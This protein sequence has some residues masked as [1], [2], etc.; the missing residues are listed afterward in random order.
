[1]SDA[2]AT[3]ISRMLAGRG[4]APSVPSSDPVLVHTGPVPATGDQKALWFIEQ[5]NQ[6]APLYNMAYAVTITGTP[7][8]EAVRR[9]VV[10]LPRRHDALRTGVAFSDGDCVQTRLED[11]SI[12]WTAGPC[13]R[14]SVSGRVRDLVLTP[15]ELDRPPL[16]R[17]ALWS[18]SP[19]EHVF[20]LVVHHAVADG[21]ALSLLVHDVGQNYREEA[22]REA[23]GPGPTPEPAEP[24]PTFA[25]FAL[26]QSA[27]RT[28]G[29]L[30][31]QLAW[32]VAHLGARPSAPAPEAA[33]T[34]S[35]SSPARTTSGPAPATLCELTFSREETDLVTALARRIGTSPFVVATAALLALVADGAGASGA[36]TV[37]TAVDRRG[38]DFADVVGHFVNTVLIRPRR[39]PDEDFTSWARACA[40]AL[41]EAVRNGDVPF[42]EVAAATAP[43][44]GTHRTSLCPIYMV[45]QSVSTVH[46]LAGFEARP[47]AL[48]DVP[49]QF[50]LVAHWAI[51]DGR[52][53]VDLVADS[54]RYDRARLSGLAARWK[55]ALLVATE[56]PGRSLSEITAPRPSASAPARHELPVNGAE[57]EPRPLADLFA[58]AVTQHPHRPALDTGTGT[59]TLSYRE[60][61]AVTDAIATRMISAGLQQG[62]TVELHLTRGGLLPAAALASAKV[63]AAFVVV[64]PA[65]PPARARMI[66]TA[67]SPALVVSGDAGTATPHAVVLALDAGDLMPPTTCPPPVT[68][69]ERGGPLRCDDPAYLVFTSGS[70]G[71]PKGVVNSSR[72]LAAMAAT[73]DSR[74]GGLASHRVLQLSA[75][76]FDALVF[77]TVSALTRGACLVTATDADLRPGPELVATLRD[78]RVTVAMMAPSVLAALPTDAVPHD[79]S[80]ILV[81]E[82]VPAALVQRRASTHLLFN[83]YGP[84]EATVLGA[85]TGALAAVG[86]PVPIGVPPVGTRAVIVDADDNEVPDGQVGE[87]A[88]TGVS[89]GLGYLGIDDLTRQRFGSG[90]AGHPDL[91]YFRTGDLVRRDHGQLYFV[92]RADD[93]VQIR[94]IRVEPAGVETAMCEVPGVRMAAVVDVPDHLVSRRLVGYYEGTA[95]P[96]AVRHAL[97]AVL[98]EAMVPGTLEPLNALPANTNGKIDRQELRR[99]ATAAPTT[100][101]ADS[102]PGDG[103][104]Y[105]CRDDDAGALDGG[106]V[107]AWTAVLGTTPTPSTDFFAS[108]GHSLRAADLA[109]RL[110]DLGHDVGVADIY[111]HPTAGRLNRVLT[112]DT[113]LTAHIDLEREAVLDPDI[114]TLS[115]VPTDP[116]SVAAPQAVLV[117]GATGFTGAYLLRE[118]LR[119]TGAHVYALVR[120]HDDA[121][122]RR[123][124]LAGLTGRALLRPGDEQRITAVAGDLAAPHLGLPTG[125]FLDLAERLDAIHHCAADVNLVSDYR[126]MRGANVVGTTEILRLAAARRVTPVHYISTTSVVLGLALHTGVLTED[127]PVP[128]EAVLRTGYVMSKW[129]AEQLVLAARDRG[130]PA[131]IY[132][133]SRVWGPT[134]R[135]DHNSDDA[136]WQFLRASVSVGALADGTEGGIPDMEIDMV[137]VDYVATAV[138]ALSRRPGG[139]GRNYHVVH[140]DPPPFRAFGDCLRS[141]GHHVSAVSLDEWTDLISAGSLEPDSSS[142]L[143]NSA[144]I[145]ETSAAL[146]QL[147][148]YVVDRANS[149]TDLDAAGIPCPPIDARLLSAYMGHLTASTPPAAAHPGGSR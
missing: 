101:G 47:L 59:R 123:R 117:T 73:V 124:L 98:P 2:R 86:G 33:P 97:A 64:D 102:A 107:A 142:E 14:D 110:K 6:G 62:Q 120:A 13:D 137:P 74:L 55:S 129:V 113:I 112:A 23:T 1:M 3:L 71:A 25:D 133:L 116:D 37:G 17:S 65:L 141:L 60:L 48:D 145:R 130:V 4:P 147:G 127:G 56:N 67:C 77:E 139:T 7:D 105:P 27:L 35:E 90:L 93:Q 126:Q 119:T 40:T 46:S 61:D 8:V 30:D 99:R 16:A 63:G 68:D 143:R 41:S 29:T 66:R 87:L 85:M 82:P 75:P 144:V 57:P 21:K 122:A 10:T 32:W 115:S 104:E 50:D 11:A 121:A 106:L 109:F 44:T 80:V 89:V 12:P 36:P 100:P 134:D 146:P 19:D 95:E 58:S 49:A 34:T 70:T 131:N 148:D 20:V 114:T 39:R 103:M 88:L 45:E 9:S 31:A 140:D 96:D 125:T 53:R 81:G 138:V 79:C 22:A 84:S 51:A 15:F 132:R 28:S 118:I 91:P 72:G 128:P 54:D 69:T 136:F 149:A 18:V 94:G 135:D 26:R 83:A 52:A 38:R 78:R 111:D 42:N 76:S 108:G 92:S 5:V 24:A 43:S